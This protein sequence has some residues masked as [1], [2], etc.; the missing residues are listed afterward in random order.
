MS[1][2]LGGIADRFTRRRLVVSLELL[3]AAILVALALVGRFPSVW[4]IVPVLF[5]LAMIN[6]I[7]QPARQAAVPGLVPAGQVG[8][9]NAMVAAAGTL[10][11]AAG[12]GL[13]GLIVALTFQVSGTSVLFLI[14]AATFAIAAAI[15]LGI[16]SLGGGAS[17]MRLTGALRRAWLIDAARPHLAISVLAALLLAMSFPA[18]FGLA[19]R[20]STSG[21]QTY[22]LLEV[23]LCA[24]V[25]IGTIVVGRAASIGTMRTAGAGLL[26]TG[27][28]SLAM[29]FSPSLLLVAAFLFVASIGNPI[30]TVANQTALVEAADP[31]NRGSVMAT[32]FTLVQTASIIGTAIGGLLI[33]IDPKN[34]PLIAY[35]VLAIGL[36]LLGLFALAAGR[37]ISNPLHGRPYEE[38]T[39]QAAA[40]HPINETPPTNETSLTNGVPPTDVPPTNEMTSPVSRR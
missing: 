20:I 3:R 30:Y 39:M 27:I 40:A 6:A 7:V 11:G 24:G 25:F 2:A 5:V 31:S 17:T 16:P 38:A 21:P 26:L 18:L 4:L 15:M 36:I 37:V 1:G 23:V 14:D 33:Q 13:A 35:G 8:R 28:F 19:Y 10:A 22:S 12:F 34:G 9:A 32:R 29:T